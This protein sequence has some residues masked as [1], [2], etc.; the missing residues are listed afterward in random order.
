MVGYPNFFLPDQVSLLCID[1]GGRELWVQT[2]VYRPNVPYVLFLDGDTPDSPIA[3]NLKDFPFLLA[4]ARED[5]VRDNPDLSPAYARLTQLKLDSE[6]RGDLSS[7]QFGRCNCDLLS[8]KGSMGLARAELQAL[9]ERYEHH[10]DL[11][12]LSAR[13][14]QGQIRV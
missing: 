9:L 8:M 4:G 2:A 5:A 10:Y 3:I 7:G 12:E 13:L 1:G 11:E 6:G 14:S